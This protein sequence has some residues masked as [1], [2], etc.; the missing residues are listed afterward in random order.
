MTAADLQMGDRYQTLQSLRMCIAPTMG[1]EGVQRVIDLPA[2]ERFAIGQPSRRP[3]DVAVA[4]LGPGAYERLVQP[5]VP[6]EW[7]ADEDYLFCLSFLKVDDIV[8]RCEFLGGYEPEPDDPDPRPMIE[9]MEFLKKKLAALEASG[10]VANPEVL[11]M[12]DAELATQ[13][14]KLRASESEAGR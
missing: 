2:G 14:A 7:L 13:R 3:D 11:A 12:I 5:H 9:K 4:L 1:P 6:D 8:N 10:H